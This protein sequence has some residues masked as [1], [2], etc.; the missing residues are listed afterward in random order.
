MALIHVT[1][2][3]GR[4]WH[5]PLSPDGVCTI[6]RAPVNNCLVLNDPHASR[7]HAHIKFENGVFLVVDGA[8]ADGEI[9]RSANHVFVNGEQRL[10]CVLREGDCITVGASLLRFKEE[11][12]AAAPPKVDYEDGP[13]GRTQVLVVAD[14][15]IQSALQPSP[16]IPSEPS[17]GSLRRDAY[18]LSL[19]YEMANTLGSVFDLQTIFDKATDILLRITPADRVLALLT[20]PSHPAAPGEDAPLR[21]VAMKTRDP[22]LEERAA[23]IA[24]GRTITR[25]VMRE[26]AA[27]L[28]QDAG[29]DA[30]L[31]MV[32]SIVSQGVRSTICAPLIADSNV[33]G[34]LY[35]DRLDPFSWFTRDD[36]HLVSAIASQT[37]MAVGSARAHERLAREEVARANYARFLPDYVV[38]QILEDPNSFALGGVNQ[39]VTV[40][41]AD[42]RGFTR[43]S[44]RMLPDEVLQLLNRWFAGMSEIV[45]THGGV[46]DK[47]I[48]DGLMALFGAPTVTDEDAGNAVAAAIDMQRRMTA[49]NSELRQSGLP[50]ISIGI[51][52]HTGKA[53]VGYVGSTRRS[54][55]TAIG[56]TVNV[57]AGLEARAQPGQT[58]VSEDTRK[59]AAATPFSFMPRDFVGVKSRQQPVQVFEAQ[60][61]PA[62][63]S[64]QTTERP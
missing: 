54:E 62:A 29:A 8:V 31:A 36:L 15:L 14:N 57:T 30:E 35:A 58:L 5:H 45:F 26:R 6:G 41:F 47:Y 25:K 20:D 49:V 50:E 55:Y 1:D 63:S 18:I 39:T 53:T 4:Q 28:S 64:E 19:L 10:E 44:E 21:V 23:R 24:I 33:Y 38:K 43:M 46:V 16:L 59:A 7:H 32:Q 9:K 13:L 56:D 51:G 42:I 52:L 27:L 22:K 11:K 34:A 61:A 37:A 60:A 40:L 12:A 3:S 2:A 48:G 17:V